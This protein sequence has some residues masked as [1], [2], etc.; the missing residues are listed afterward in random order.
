VFGAYTSLGEGA[1]MITEQIPGWA[2]ISPGPKALFIRLRPGVDHDAAAARIEEGL[3][4]ISALAGTAELLAVQRPAE[5]VNYESMGATPA[6]LAAVLVL[7]AVVSLGLTLASGVGRR[8][9]ELSILKSLGF[10]RRQVSATVVWQSSLI[11]AIGLVVGLPLGI[12]L[13]RWLWILFAGRLPVLA[14]PT[15]PVLVLAAIACGLVVVANL[16]AAVPAR[17]AGRTP[18]ASILRSE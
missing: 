17:A 16:V 7:A 8:R 18:V 6:L 3:P 5:I 9:R 13:G 10:T 14:R 4:G 11:V 2:Q 12:A 1:M 15:V